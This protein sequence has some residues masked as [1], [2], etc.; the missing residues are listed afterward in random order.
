MHSFYNLLVV[1]TEEELMA[2]AS[3]AVVEIGGGVAVVDGNGAIV[4]RWA[5]PL[6]GIFSDEQAEQVRQDFNRTNEAIR[7]IGCEFASPL[8]ALSFVSLATIPRLG[9][10]HAGLYD[11]N[12]Q[13]H[14]NVLLEHQ[15]ASEAGN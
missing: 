8:L 5:L 7:S 14:I 3:A 1:G 11:V 2:R 4:N 12:E 9:M 10:T 6:V 13:R 15:D